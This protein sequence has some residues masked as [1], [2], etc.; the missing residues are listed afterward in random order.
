MSK[1]ELARQSARILTY[2]VPTAF[3]GENA[4]AIGL[5]ADRLAEIGAYSVMLTEGHVNSVEL[6]DSAGIGAFMQIQLWLMAQV[7]EAKRVSFDDVLVELGE[8]IDSP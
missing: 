8:H 7:A 3:G 2:G 1:S 4:D 6:D 5:A